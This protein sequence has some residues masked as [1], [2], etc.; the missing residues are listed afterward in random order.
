MRVWSK[1]IRV[2]LSQIA[3]LLRHNALLPA[4][5]TTSHFFN[6]FICNKLSLTTIFLSFL[7][8][9]LVEKEVFNVAS[10]CG[11]FDIPYNYLMISPIHSLLIDR[12]TAR[13]LLPI[14]TGFR[15]HHGKDRPRVI[16]VCRLMVL[17]MSIT[18]LWRSISGGCARS[19]P[20]G[21]MLVEPAATLSTDLLL[22]MSN[23]LAE[24]VQDDVSQ[25]RLLLTLR[26]SGIISDFLGSR[27][28]QPAR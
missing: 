4:L 16:K 1:G 8:D 24:V 11:R 5:D 26:N 17:K 14:R 21:G 13:I 25:A 12:G 23:L 15:L 7:G 28:Y 9:K 27:L 2:Q 18:Q 20:N 3:I 10:I 19:L 22:K 6:L